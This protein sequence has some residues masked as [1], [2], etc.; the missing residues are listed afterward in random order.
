MVIQKMNASFSHSLVYD[1]QRKRDPII[2]K[3]FGL[4]TIQLGASK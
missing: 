3:I 4:L 2:Y 1:I